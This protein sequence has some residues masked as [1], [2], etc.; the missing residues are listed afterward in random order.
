MEKTLY[1]RIVT[2]FDRVSSSRARSAVV[3]FVVTLV[4]F[5]A[6]CCAWAPNGVYDD[7]SISNAL[8]ANWGED[9]GLCLF[10]NAMLARLIFQLNSMFGNINWFFMAER[11]CSFAAYFSIVYCALTRLKLPFFGIV[12]F[13]ATVLV[14]PGCTYESNF[15]YVSGMLVGAGG[16]A[17]L[18]SLS[19][20]RH[21]RGLICAG[22]LLMTLGTLFRWTMFLL[23]VPVFGVA[24]L[25]VLFGRKCAVDGGAKDAGNVED[26]AAAPVGRSAARLWPFAVALLLFAGLYGYNSMAWS[27]EPWSEWYAFNEARS[28]ISDY[29]YESYD[30][31][32]DELSSIGVSEND[33]M[34]LKSWVSEDPDFFTTEKLEA[35]R[36]IVTDR[37]S[38]PARIFSTV[39]GYFKNMA[40]S[41][42]LDVLVAALLVALICFT[43]GRA[44]GYSVALLVGVAILCWALYA[45]GRL[46]AR[47]MLPVWV[48]AAIAICVIGGLKARSSGLAANV[49]DCSAGTSESGGEGRLSSLSAP[50][51]LTSKV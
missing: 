27:E 9:E 45:F 31:V 19:Q 41:V 16:F 33:Y 8:S 18:C 24:A 20:S 39:P 11:L 37:R 7:W 47:V 2:S 21:T 35:I 48:F 17:L 23:C 51:E 14:L 46:P 40:S 15:T 5:G 6:A 12:L 25:L 28:D 10:L 32:K 1:G 30:K 42:R 3:A 38:S 4:V 43:R 26:A 44:K 22:L 29:S 36:D 34:L 50:A 49:A 13:G